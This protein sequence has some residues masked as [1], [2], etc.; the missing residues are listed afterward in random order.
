MPEFAEA[1]AI[2]A[3]D[4][5]ALRRTDLWVYLATGIIS[6]ALVAYALTMSFVW[7]EGFHA[8][9]AQLILHGKTPYIDFCFPQTPLNAYWNALWMRAFGESWRVL[10]IP[11]ALEIAGAMFLV[12]EFLLAHF[13]VTRWRGAVALAAVCFIGLLSVLV[14][15]GPIAQAYAPGMLLVVAAFRVAVAHPNEPRKPTL[16]FF[17]GLLSSAAAG[18]TLLTAPA[19]AVLFI[20]FCLPKRA[21]SRLKNAAAFI[22]AALIP[23]MPLLW[24][25]ARAPRVVFFNVVQYQA[26]F[27]RVNWPGATT[28]DID[29]L[30]AW[31]ADVQTMLLLALFLYGL[32]F[33][34]RRSAWPSSARLPFY[35]AAAL[36]A[37]LGLYIATAHPTFARYFIVAVPV[38]SIVSATGLYAFGLRIT[39][40]GNPLW[41]TIMLVGVM[42]LGYG[43]GLFEDRDSATWPEYEEIAAKVKQVTPKSGMLYA[44]EL[45]YFLLKQSPPSGMEFSYSH[46]M[47]L[48]P[49]EERRYH[50]ISQKE[51]DTEV[52]A[53]RF[54]T[55]QTCNDDL[56]DEMHLDQI[57]AHKAE[58]KDCS[59]YWGKIPSKL[60][61]SKK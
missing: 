42:L 13:P 57:F 26:I 30:S 25:F 58:V 21:A 32:Y 14:Q 16:A 40:S 52:A 51:L 1:S 53:G 18:C 35:L 15:F 50:V 5:A 41:P 48:S 56:I 45:V 8:V 54:D 39:D 43:R 7:D 4:T 28:H 11:A 36:S 47:E 34:C 17:S 49:T 38:I 12:A 23:C 31:L 10:H 24:L 61:S 22:G 37:A 33:I 55:V 27:R 3:A 29:V 44:D 59:I 2:E 9:A 20:W 46:R 60:T 6:A 19:V